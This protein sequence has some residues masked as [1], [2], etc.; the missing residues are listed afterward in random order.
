MFSQAHLYADDVQ[1]YASGQ[2]TD[3]DRV[4]KKLNADMSEQ[5]LALVTRKRSFFKSTK[6][7]SYSNKL[8]IAAHLKLSTNFTKNL[9]KIIKDILNW[10]DLVIQKVYKTLCRLW[11]L[12]VLFQRSLGLRARGYKGTESL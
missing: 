10:N 2:F 7:I 12:G 9:G 8:A 11:T 5:Y 1:I 3:A 6:I 4:I